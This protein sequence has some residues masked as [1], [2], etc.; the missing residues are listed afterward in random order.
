MK[1]SNCITQQ[2]LKV[3]NCFT[4]KARFIFLLFKMINLLPVDGDIIYIHF[5]KKTVLP[6]EFTLVRMWVDFS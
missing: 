6:P 2:E 5:Q 4:C 3:Q 1:P